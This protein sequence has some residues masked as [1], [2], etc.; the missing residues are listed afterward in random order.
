[1]RPNRDVRGERVRQTPHL[2][3]AGLA[4]PSKHRSLTHRLPVELFKHLQLGIDVVA[5]QLGDPAPLLHCCLEAIQPAVELRRPI[6]QHNPSIAA[7]LYRLQAIYRSGGRSASLIAV[8][9]RRLICVD[10]ARF[11]AVRYQSPTAAVTFMA[12]H[13]ELL[14][15]TN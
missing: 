2:I 8:R 4:D 11:R 15:S 1:M 3:L 13:G 14:L 5:L 9:P 7:E 6:D 10:P 12:F